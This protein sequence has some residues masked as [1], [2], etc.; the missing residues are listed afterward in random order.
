MKTNLI[1]LRNSDLGK[2][3]I[4]R[5][6]FKKLILNAITPFCE[7]ILKIIT[8]FLKWVLLKIKK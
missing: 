8:L 5:L 2:F 3:E 1:H 6:R 7:S 4:A